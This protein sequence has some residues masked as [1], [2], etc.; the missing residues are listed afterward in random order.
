MKQQTFPLL[1]GAFASGAL[2]A[3]LTWNSKNHFPGESNATLDPPG[4][5]RSGTVEIGPEVRPQGVAALSSI[6]LE[7]LRGALARKS[8]RRLVAEL[9]RRVETL[10]AAELKRLLLEALAGSEDDWRNREIVGLLLER[11]E[12]LDSPGIISLIGQL[13]K[14]QKAGAVSLLA[15]LN[16]ATALSLF[17]SLT[18]AELAD[19]LSDPDALGRIATHNPP[20]LAALLERLPGNNAT[21]A[22]YARLAE[23]WAETDPAKALALANGIGLDAI[24]T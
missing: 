11:L 1:F 3:S 24:R 15:A 22:N 18:D 7:A 14:E 5:E 6:S 23:V 8:S 12:E 21:A 4:K 2:L 16:P 9:W 17:K 20:D 13:S 19:A 10:P